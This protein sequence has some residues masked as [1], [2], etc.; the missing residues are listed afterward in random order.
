MRAYL[1]GGLKMGPKVLSK[2]TDIYARR[3]VET[4]V[5]PLNFVSVLC[6]DP[7]AHR[8]YAEVQQSMAQED[9]VHLHVLSGA[10]HLVTNLFTMH[11]ELKEKVCSQI[12]DSPC[13]IDG[14]TP[15]LRE[16]YGVPPVVTR[17][18][19]ATLF[20]DCLKTSEQF[21]R[22]PVIEGVRTGVIYSEQ[23]VISPVRSI[24]QMVEV[25]SAGVEMYEMKTKSKHLLHFRD[26]RDRY[27]ALVDDV[28]Q[29]S[30]I[31]SDAA[32]DAM[33]VQA[34]AAA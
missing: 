8:L 20:P 26:E 3:G 7:A 15:A 19:T 9:A 23:D 4:S 27:E 28:L 13:H 5:V 34:A 29:L 1:F 21:M 32:V 12:Y 31:V 33:G 10:C 18:L 24:E 6:R 22:E 16:F 2:F 17:S 14:M 11:P 30:P 25:W